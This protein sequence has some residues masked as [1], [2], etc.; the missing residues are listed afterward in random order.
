MST[1][2]ASCDTCGLHVPE[3]SRYFDGMLLTRKDL[4]AEQKYLRGR[5]RLH[6]GLL[7]GTGTVCGLKVTQHPQPA[8][9]SRY[10]YLHPGLA[11]DCCGNAI[12]V[13]ERVRVDLREL[14]ETA[15]RTGHG[16]PEEGLPGPTDIYLRLG[17]AEQEAELVPSLVDECGCNETA[18]E[19]SRTQESYR[20]WVD[21][22][23]PPALA[24]DPLEVSAEHA[25]TLEVNEP[26]AIFEDRELSRLYVADWDGKHGWL[27]TYNAQT[28]SLL[29]RVRTTA[30][31]GERTDPRQATAAG[32]S[33]RGERLY[34]ALSNDQGAE[35]AIFTQDLLQASPA[36]ARVGA[37][38]VPG[39]AAVVAVASAVRDD[40][41]LALTRDGRLLRWRVEAL[42][43][44]DGTRAAPAPLEVSL[45]DLI[46]DPTLTAGDMTQSADGRWLVVA[47]AGASRVVVVNLQQLG[48][49]VA[50]ANLAREFALP[51]DEI[52]TAIELSYDGRYLYLLCPEARRLY[53]AVVRDRLEDF[54][55]QIP[56]EGNA[57]SELPLGPDDEPVSA[58]ALSVSPR[59]NWVYVLCREF[60]PDDSVRD[61]G[62]VIAIPVEALDEHRGRGTIDDE[63][64]ASLRQELESADGAPLFQRLAF[65]GQRLYVAGDKH[66]QDAPAFEGAISVLLLSELASDIYLRRTIEGCPACETADG[67]VLASIAGYRWDEPMVD[68]ADD[69]PNVLDNLTYRPLVPSTDSLRRVIESMLKKGISEGIPGPRGPVGP[70]GERAP[71][72]TQATASTLEPDAA[73]TASVTPVPGDPQKLRAA[74]GVPRARVI[75]QV[76][77]TA[78][79]APGAGSTATLTPINPGRPQGD[80]RLTLALERPQAAALTVVSHASFHHD[81][82]MTIDEL[83]DLVGRVGLVV[84]FNAPVR[85]Q[86]LHDRSVFLLARKGGEALS[87]EC[88]LPAAVNAVDVATNQLDRRD[89]VIRVGNTSEQASYQLVNQCTVA[90][91]ASANAVRL[92]LDAAGLKALVDA[93]VSR[94]TVVLRGDLILDAANGLALD[95]NHVWPG[96][97]DRPSGNGAQGDDWI[98]IIHITDAG[99]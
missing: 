80:Q 45:A 56:A 40:A 93:K 42:D 46:G 69:G 78:P 10:V 79:T 81:E 72:L 85:S 7:H 51:D 44:W 53:R 48:P 97:P 30:E 17:Y 87:C 61:R 21:L 39:Q 14:I 70:Q 58:V 49:D 4:D 31:R 13:P 19:Y 67:V 65:L 76:A 75:S 29:S 28:H 8:C 41:L 32:R 23:T 33:N 94:L 52:A 6:T 36:A 9:R 3:R 20:L 95:G 57:F 27:R 1:V 43:A 55:P 35:I 92:Q 59:D 68:D 82:E 86:T 96:V 89:I 60:E 34:V 83:K 71:V 88:V 16:F 66:P 11:N 2:E 91:G 99:P 74:L 62:H 50:A 77:V 47:D 24:S 90:I 38:A 26:R 37:L 25:F 63:L 5:N 64:A 84:R 54:L 18:L 73:P 98:S 22:E 12:V 15:L